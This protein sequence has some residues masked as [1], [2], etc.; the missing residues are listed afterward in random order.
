MTAQTDV[1]HD[2]TCLHHLLA[3]RSSW[4]TQKEANQGKL[5]LYTHEMQMRFSN[6]QCACARHYK[7]FTDGAWE[8]Q[9]ARTHDNRTLY[10]VLTANSQ[11]THERQTC[12]T[13]L[14]SDHT[15]CYAPSVHRTVVRRTRRTRLGRRMA[16]AL[17][18]HVASHCTTK[19]SHRASNR[20]LQA[21]RV[22]C[23]NGNSEA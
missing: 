14:T 20:R 23:V 6:A 17:E 3:L 7:F 16:G 1:S 9:D 10:V 2:T 12:L 18:V 5:Q 22:P 13:L 11:T 4:L 21:R 19:C 15:A 8:T